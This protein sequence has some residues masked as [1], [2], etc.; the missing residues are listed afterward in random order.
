MGNMPRRIDR[1]KRETIGGEEF[2][3]AAEA[4]NDVPTTL[5]VDPQA[6]KLA[7]VKTILAAEKAFKALLQGLGSS[8]SLSIA[9]QRIEEARMW[10]VDGIINER[11]AEAPK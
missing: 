4:V 5:S 3:D 8:R 7:K 11:P 10:A 2:T 9:R 1:I 6:E